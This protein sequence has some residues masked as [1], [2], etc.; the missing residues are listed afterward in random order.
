MVPVQFCRENCSRPVSATLLDN[1][2]R[3]DPEL[4]CAVNEVKVLV[5]PQFA[6]L[7]PVVKAGEKVG[8]FPRKSSLKFP[9]GQRRNLPTDK[10]HPL[11]CFYPLEKRWNSIPG[12]MSQSPCCRAAHE[13]LI[14]PRPAPLC[15]TVRAVPADDAPELLRAAAARGQSPAAARRLRTAR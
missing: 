7:P 14:T 9:A 6:R 10:K 3:E 12:L 11:G 1:E 5:R 8:E 15:R 2:I 4:L 13:S